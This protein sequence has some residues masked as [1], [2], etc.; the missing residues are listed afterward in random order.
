MRTR[1]LTYTS[2]DNSNNNNS[3]STMLSSM[4]PSTRT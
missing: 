1:K 4:R 3:I 2:D